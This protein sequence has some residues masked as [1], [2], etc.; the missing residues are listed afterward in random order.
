MR[1]WR[2][3]LLLKV[4]VVAF[5]RLSKRWWMEMEMDGPR[6]GKEQRDDLWAGQL[7]F[8]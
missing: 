6:R 7:S 3:L 2:K 8:D 5:A 4:N 1:I